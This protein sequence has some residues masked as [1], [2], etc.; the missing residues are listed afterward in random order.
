[1]NA[2]DCQ[3]RSDYVKEHYDSARVEF[4]LADAG[5]VIRKLEAQ[6]DAL[7]LMNGT[8]CTGECNPGNCAASHRA[9]AGWDLVEA[10]ATFDREVSI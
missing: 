1:M 2:R 9:E 5:H 8:P 3:R 7:H 4:P 10:G 6:Y